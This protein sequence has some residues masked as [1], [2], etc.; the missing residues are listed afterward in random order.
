M[1]LGASLIA[2]VENAASKSRTEIPELVGVS[3]YE[4]LNTFCIGLAE[5]VASLEVTLAEEKASRKALESL[6]SQ[7]LKEMQANPVTK[8]VTG[9]EQSPR[10]SPEREVVTKPASEKK[11]VTKPVN[12]PEVVTKLEID[13]QLVSA[14]G[15]RWGNIRVD[16][17]PPTAEQRQILD[18]VSTGAITK[19]EAFAGTGKT[20]TLKAIASAYP[21]KRFLYLAFN[22]AIQKEAAQTFPHNVSAKTAH[23]LAFRAVMMMDGYRNIRVGTESRLVYRLNKS[24]NS[25]EMARQLNV[26][27]ENVGPFSGPQIIGMARDMVRKFE[28]SDDSQINPDVHLKGDTA[29]MIQS[30]KGVSELVS[31]IVY[32]M[33]MAIWEKIQDP[34]DDIPLS[35]DS[36]LKLWALSEPEFSGY[37]AVLFDEAQDA[38]PV[39]LNIVRSQKCQQIYVGDENQQIYSWRGAVSAMQKIEAQTGYLT[40]SFRFGPII[41]GVASDI[42][43]KLGGSRKVLGRATDDGCLTVDYGCK[44]TMIFRTNAQLITEALRLS[45]Y[46]DIHIV[47]GIRGG[48]QDLKDAFSIYR[49][50]V[51]RGRFASYTS[52]EM[53]KVVSATDPEIKRLYDF[54]EKHGSETEEIIRKL[55]QLAACPEKDAAV[56]LSTAHKS[57]GRQW[58]QVLIGEDFNAGRKSGRIVDPS[59]EEIRLIYVAVTR[60]KKALQLSPEI[61]QWLYPPEPD[62]ESE[63]KDDDVLI[64]EIM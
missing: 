27:N 23:S 59:G 9:P 41:A 51:G 49:H 40:D 57:K 19:I 63:E 35:H 2:V 53:V 16:G 31:E 18:L 47:G 1:V 61:S 36:Y 13:P 29:A 14:S 64:P 37:N 46:H 56:I 5:R 39:I 24:W 38:N 22:K 17:F 43:E 34:A 42:L 8:P 55:D 58:D 30:S 60:A 4:K 15:Q 50:G 3:A 25:F 44:Y 28:Q 48:V 21:K 6:V 62:F 45:R 7:H 32:K 12:F 20:S 11:P 52:W 10:E 26:I 54:I 33:A